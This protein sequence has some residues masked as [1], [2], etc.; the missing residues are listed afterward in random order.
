MKHRFI[1]TVLIAVALIAWSVDGR[2]QGTDH[3]AHHAPGAAPAVQGAEF[4]VGD[5]RR[6]EVDAKRLTVRHGPIQN[7]GLAE[8]TTVFQ[9][10][11][12][13]MLEGLTLDDRVRFKADRIDGVY[14]VTAI[15][16]VR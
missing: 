16:P 8:T 13:R 1:P 11:D 4:V 2:A 7:L 12:A 5:V 14:T 6:V 9:V 10:R 15:E 3:A